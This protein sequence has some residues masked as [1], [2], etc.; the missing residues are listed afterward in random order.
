[1][2]A[3]DQP[4]CRQRLLVL[5]VRRAASNARQ[6]WVEFSVTDQGSG[7]DAAVAEQLFTPFFTTKAEGMGLG[8]SLCRTVVEQHGGHMDHFPNPAGG[9]VFRFT[10]PVAQPQ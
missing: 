4:E 1:M 6:G 2:Q 5:Q 8:L 10:L 7:I 3:M 9:T